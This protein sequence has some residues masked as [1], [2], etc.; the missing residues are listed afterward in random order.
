[1]KLNLLGIVDVLLMGGK[2]AGKSMLGGQIMYKTDTADKEMEK[3]VKVKFKGWTL[4]C[5]GLHQKFL[6]M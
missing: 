3:L 1:M 5:R 6:I 2:A 4:G